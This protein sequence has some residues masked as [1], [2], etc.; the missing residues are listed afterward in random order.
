M[1]K[2]PEFVPVLTDKGWRVTVSPMMSPTGKKLRKFFP[3]EKAADRYA[4]RIRGQYHR[5]E[6]GINLATDVAADAKEAMDILEGTGI[7]LVDAAKAALTMHQAAGKSETFGDRYKRALMEGEMRWRPSYAKDMSKLKDWVGKDFM[8]RPCSIITPTMIEEEIQSRGTY[9]QSTVQQRMRYISAILNYKTRHRKTKEI[10]ILTD[11]QC[12]AMLA[13]APTAEDRR[14]VALLIFAGIRPSAEDGEISRMDWEA[15][16]DKHIYIAGDVAK[17]GTDRHIPITP[18]LRHYLKGHPKSGRVLPTRW[19][20]N[21]KEIRRTVGITASDITR[22]TFASHFLAAFGEEAT[23]Q[24]MGHTANSQTLFRHYRKAV[25][26][27]DGERFFKY[28]IPKKKKEP[29]KE[30]SK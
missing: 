14:V 29:E 12:L 8:A 18:R 6:R 13:A 27:E 24:A 15:V 20:K 21:Y 1:P 19:V 7:T 28:P 26:K 17:T 9:K 4:Q 23:K 16:E 30:E 22:H 25:T 10:H 11:D 2:R 3:D 5:G